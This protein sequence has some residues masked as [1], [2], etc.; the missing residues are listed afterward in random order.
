M[1]KRPD[2][3]LVA[4]VFPADLH[5]EADVRRLHRRRLDRAGQARD[6]GPHLPRGEGASGQ[7]RA[8]ARRR[9]RH[10]DPADGRALQ[11]VRRGR[12][13]RAQDEPGQR[14]ASGP[15]IA[16][17]LQ[18]PDRRRASS[19]SSTAAPRSARTSP[20]TRR[21]TRCTSPART[22]RTTRSSGARIRR[23]RS[24]ARRA[25]DAEQHAPFTAE[26][27]CVTPVL[28]VPGP[29]TR[30]RPRVPG[31]PRRGHGHAERQLQL[32]RRQGA[33]HREGLAAA[34]GVPRR[35]CTPRSARDAARKAYYPGAR[36]ALSRRS[37]R[38]PA[39]EGARR[40]ESRRRR[41]VDRHPDVPARAGEYA[42]TNEAFCG[43]LA[44]VDARRRTTRAR[45][46]RARPS[47]FA[48]E[49]LLGHALVHA[50]RAPVDAAR[51]TPTRSTARSRAF[52]TAASA[53]TSGP[54]I[55]YA[56]VSPTWGAFPGHPTD[57]HPV[58]HAA[59]CTT[60]SCSTT[61][62]SPWCARRSGSADAGVVLRSQEPEGARPGVVEDGNFARVS[63]AS[64]G[65]R[66][67]V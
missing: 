20:S 7:G 48:N 36:E 55:I 41:A 42:L 11:A 18:S 12:G 66:S 53:S 40:A 52:A 43:V 16:R 59:S 57:G 39:G 34:R 10:V 49:R 22:A 62:R 58:G 44:E 5:G 1:I 27:G 67:R 31:A 46:P 6:A 8:R 15:H 25:G 37:S 64:W 51:A 33:G 19:R 47:T 61:R 50:A 54:G 13:R 60:R 24:G 65:R 17:A 30:R 35:R 2:G 63:A 38:I 56:L 4:R 28:V 26:L 9:Q 32:Q 23:S 3:Q 21:S 29:W 14:R 45:V